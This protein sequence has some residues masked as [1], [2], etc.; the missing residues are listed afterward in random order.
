MTN[1]LT[2]HAMVRN[3]PF[4][5]YSVMSVYPYVDKI[6]LWDTG[7]DDHT[8]SDIQ[9]LLRR[10]TEGKIDFRKKTIETDERYWRVDK[11]AQL[12]E[13]NKGKKGKGVIRQEM[14]DA[15]AT[16]FFLI[17]DGDEVWYEEGML[18]VLDWISISRCLEKRICARTALR[19][20]CSMSEWFWVTSS[21]RVFKTNRVIMSTASPG[22]MHMDK[23]NPTV[24]SLGLGKPGVTIIDD[25]PPYA[26]YETFL[27]PWRREADPAKIVTCEP[28]TFHP[29]VIYQFPQYLTRFSEHLKKGEVRARV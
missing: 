7:S 10:D 25:M 28:A 29:K 13:Q 27:K 4:V 21:T 2:V 11:A 15:T 22:E 18:R 1:G 12:R 23:Q 5:F 8:F 3:E 26:H 24:N 16:D 6:L 19:W 9:D 14:I 20:F 17:L